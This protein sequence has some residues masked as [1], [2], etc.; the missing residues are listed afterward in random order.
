MAD[1][2][3]TDSTAVPE[4][5]IALTFVRSAGPGGQNVNKVS[6]AVE[7]RLDLDAAKLKPMVRARLERIVGSRLTQGGEIIIFAQRFRTQK[8]NRED[9]FERLAEFVARAERHPKRRIATKPTH[10]SKQRRR[11]TKT[12][13]GS[14]KKLRGKPGSDD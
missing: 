6:T 11:T 13:L 1:I 12:H 4:S 9:A 7:L 5:A 10:A 3:L 2:Q 8:A 14:V